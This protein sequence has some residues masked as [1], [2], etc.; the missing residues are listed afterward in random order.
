MDL[1]PY[2]SASGVRELAGKAGEVHH[3]A[4]RIFFA[5][6]PLKGIDANLFRLLVTVVDE[7]KLAIHVSSVDTGAHVV[8][9]RHYQGRAVDISRV[10]D[11]GGMVMI[12]TLTNKGALRLVTTLLVE[13]FNVGEG[14]PQAAVLFGPIRSTFNNS[15]INHADH[16]H[17]SLPKK[18]G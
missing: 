17:V 3:G 15:A 6:A 13:G 12:A 10:G 1:T 5:N 2:L 16:I 4:G 9:S 18:K 8:N 7:L 11:A 14:R